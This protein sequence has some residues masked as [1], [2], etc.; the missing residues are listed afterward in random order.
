MG[1]SV[2]LIRSWLNAR[3]DCT[4]MVVVC[5]TFSWEDYPVHVTKDENV[6]DVINKYDNKGMQKI[7]E[8]YSYTL[9]IEEQLNEYR[10]FHV[11]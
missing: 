4:H 5:D 7:M 2:E 8:C 10:A 11:D 1:T 6:L 3:T 9:D